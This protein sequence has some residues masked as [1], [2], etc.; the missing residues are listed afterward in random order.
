MS[1]AYDNSGNLTWT[2]SVTTPSSGT[3]TL[4]FPDYHYQWYPSF[5]YTDPTIATLQDTVKK[6]EDRIRELEMQ[7]LQPED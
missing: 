2:G 7:L 3:V 1:L 4:T 6:L 5:T